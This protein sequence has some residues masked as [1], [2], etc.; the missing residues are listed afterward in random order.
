MKTQKKKKDKKM[1][2]QKTYVALVLDQSG[3]MSTRKA[4]AA[5]GYNEQVQQMKINSKDQDIFCSLITFNGD[6]FEH[7]WCE[8]A[9]D[10]VE[11]TAEDYETN[12]STAMHDAI[13]YTIEKLK[14]TTE[15]D[16]NT[17]YL[18]VVISDGDEN[19][20]RHYKDPALLRKLIEGCQKTGKWTFTYMG[21]DAAYLQ[22]VAEETAIPL[23]NMA[24]WSTATPE[25]AT[26]GL[27][28]NSARVG[29]YY[30]CRAGG[31]T[32]SANVYSDKSCV[33]ADFTAEDHSADLISAGGAVDMSVKAADILKNANPPL[34][35]NV[36]VG[37]GAGTSPFSNY[38]PVDWKI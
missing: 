31:A 22:K 34:N 35:V 33:L 17:A 30:K 37:T 1:A 32:A 4:E 24:M 6:V 20:S 38:N 10:M 19:A 15:A 18:V 12:G 9:E 8:K 2:R 23:A 26:R 3:S 7:K 25:L 21:C 5:Q 29:G 16:D 28:L 27:H 14:K 36:N 13:A 11:A